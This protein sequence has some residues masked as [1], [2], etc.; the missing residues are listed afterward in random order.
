MEASLSCILFILS[1]QTSQYLRLA[2]PAVVHL[3]KIKPEC[4]DRERFGHAERMRKIIDSCSLIK[5]TFCPPLLFSNCHLQLLLFMIKNE[6]TP[7]RYNWIRELVE[8]PDGE[9]K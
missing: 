2:K 7:S 3:S 6:L 4:G 9:G 5:K 8:L 1:V